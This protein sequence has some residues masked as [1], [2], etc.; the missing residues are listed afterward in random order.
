MAMRSWPADWELRLAGAECPACSQGRPDEDEYGVRYFAGTCADAYLQRSTPVPGYST[1][2]FRGRH[3]ADPTD[4]TPDESVGFWSD[5][6]IAARAIR[7]VFAPCHLNYQ[8]LGNAM[9]HVHVHVIP[10]YLDDS[11]P[12]RPLGDEVWNSATVLS[13]LELEAQVIA[14]K[15]VVRDSPEHL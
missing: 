11:A 12:G 3:V 8:L 13:S 9:P 4:L 14:L 15:S 7:A 10:R 5:V 6:R 1:V 2:I